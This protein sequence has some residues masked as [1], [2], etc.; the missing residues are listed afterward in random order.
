MECFRQRDRERY[1]RPDLYEALKQY[2]RER[3]HLPEVYS[4]E[5]EYRALPEVKERARR[6]AKKPENILKARLQGAHRRALKT[7]AT[8]PWLTD[9]DHDAIKAIYADA[10]SLSDETGVQHQVDHIVPLKH[11]LVCGLHIPANLQVLTSH[12]NNAKNNSFDGT[13]DNDGWRS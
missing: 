13:M 7:K 12:D 4:R 2:S 10:Q 1:Y 9:R 3:Y 8:P 5:A 11:P 6:N